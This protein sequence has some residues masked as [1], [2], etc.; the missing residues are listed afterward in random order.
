MVGDFIAGGMADGLENA[1]S[2]V[3]NVKVV[4]KTNGSSGFVRDDFYDWPGEIKSIIAEVDPSIV[5]MLIGSND[6]QAM[7][8]DGRTEKVRSAAWEKEYVSRVNAFADAVKETGTALVWAGS[9]PFR[10]KSM[11]AD[12][13]AFNEFYRAAA[14]RVGGYFVDIWD[15]FVD[16][17]GNFIA[18]GSDVNG[19]TVQLRS[20]D[21]INF[22]R[23][24]KRKLA[25]YVERQIRQLLGDAAAPQITSLAPDSFSTMRLPP[26]QSESEPV[27][28][29][30]MK[31]TDP[32]LDGGAALLGDIT[33]PVPEA[34]D[35]T[36]QGK[37]VRR[38]L[39]ENG[40]PPPEQPGRANDFDWSRLQQE[41][42][43]R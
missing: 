7:R 17:D 2:D 8:V 12:I 28:L 43:V 33:A 3:Q 15:G 6:R 31:I 11:S 20:S 13:L 27:H 1:F 21:G 35:D 36:L 41:E 30:P 25:F 19:Q 37:S 29:N 4:D 26:L 39:V 42:A 34:P 10:F 24:G 18:K 9:P 23:D 14:E 32:E 40:I 16:A 38:R 22:T 5:V